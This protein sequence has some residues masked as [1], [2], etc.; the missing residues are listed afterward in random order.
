VNGVQS[1]A[2][3]DE[4]PIVSLEKYARELWCGSSLLPFPFGWKVKFQRFRTL[5]VPPPTTTT[6]QYS[7]KNEKN[8][9]SFL[10]P[11]DAFK[12]TDD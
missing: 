4:R 6:T 3:D 2:D 11:L 10:I 7:E 9:T 1:T 8:S 12:V 5:P